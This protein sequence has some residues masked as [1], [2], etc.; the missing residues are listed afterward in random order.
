M[1]HYSYPPLPPTG[2]MFL[3]WCVNC[4]RMPHQNRFWLLGFMAVD[5][6]TDNLNLIKV[7]QHRPMT[8]KKT[9]QTFMSCPQ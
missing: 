9:N 7:F 6:Y 5:S 3:S 4:H 1:W 8:D 2:A